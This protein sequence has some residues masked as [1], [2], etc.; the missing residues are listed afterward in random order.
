M[1]V[2]LYNLARIE[3]N[4]GRLDEAK[5]LYDESLD[6]LKESGDSVGIA[7]TL[8]ELG[9][10]EQQRGNYPEAKKLY[11]QSLGIRQKLR[12]QSGATH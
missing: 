12:D 3:L 10:I 11:D 7:N 5:L 1:A 4:E 9:M 2:T 8:H 6:I